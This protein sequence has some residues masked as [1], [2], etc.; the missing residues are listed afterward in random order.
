MRPISVYVCIYAYICVIYACIC[1]F[2]VRLK[3]D[4]QLALQRIQKI[5]FPSPS[6]LTRSKTPSAGG[7]AN[8]YRSAP[9]GELGM[10][11][12]TMSKHGSNLVRSGSRDKYETSGSNSLPLSRT[13][14]GG[15]SSSVKRGSGGMNGENGGGMSVKSTLIANN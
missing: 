10:G 5:C 1:A 13:T 12:G 7:L 2:V 14:S 9:S 15:A 3:F 4:S 11:S 8:L 6:L